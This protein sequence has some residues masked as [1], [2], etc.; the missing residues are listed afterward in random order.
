MLTSSY[1]GMCPLCQKCNLCY[2]EC[3][4]CICTTGQ[5]W[6]ML[7]WSGF[8]S[9]FK[10]NPAAHHWSHPC[11]EAEMYVKFSL[12]LQLCLILRFW[13][14]LSVWKSQIQTWSQL[15]IWIVH[16]ETTY[17]HEPKVIQTCSRWNSCTFGS[18]YWTL[19]ASWI[20]KWPSVLKVCMSCPKE[21]GE[22]EW[23]TSWMLGQNLFCVLRMCSLRVSR[24]WDS[25]QRICTWS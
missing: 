2:K 12:S 6:T 16:A 4:L 17:A 25:G 20:Q 24:I 13:V 15:F 5:G 22:E 10:H 11:K 14:D 1:S 7:C 3:R 8:A 18:C 19:Q 21:W 23:E 9:S